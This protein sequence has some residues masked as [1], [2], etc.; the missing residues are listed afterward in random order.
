VVSGALPVAGRA[1]SATGVAVPRA[2]QVIPVGPTVFPQ[3][4]V[5]WVDPMVIGEMGPV[6]MQQGCKINGPPVSQTSPQLSLGEA[7]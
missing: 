4:D 5:C 3:F 6:V 1:A 7:E 2:S